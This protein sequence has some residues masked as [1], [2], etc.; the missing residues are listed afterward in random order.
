MSLLIAKNINKKFFYTDKTI[1]V[2]ED[3]SLS[4]NV[5]ESI[6]IMGKSGSGKSSLLHIL[7]GLDKPCKGEVIFKKTLFT[8]KIKNICQIIEIIK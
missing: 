6:A 3:I 4:V 8:I 5:E 2:L 1:D 7:G